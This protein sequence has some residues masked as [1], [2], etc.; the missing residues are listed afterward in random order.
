MCEN[1]AAAIRELGAECAGALKRRL[2]D[3]RAVENVAELVAGR[4]RKASNSDKDLM[5]DLSDSF[6]LVLHANHTPIPRIDSGGVDWSRVS[7]VKLLRIERN[8]G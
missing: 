3:L 7:R 4:P 2:A 6:V 5:I 1:E 8:N